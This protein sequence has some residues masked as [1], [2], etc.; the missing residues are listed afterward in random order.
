MSAVTGGWVNV[1]RGVRESF[2]GAWQ[3]HVSAD[4]PQTL[5]Q[6]SVI[7]ACVTG[8]AQDVSKLRIKLVENI[9]G[10]WEEVTEGKPWLPVLRKPNGYQTRIQFIRQWVVSLLL[11]GNT[12]VLKARD[13]RRIVT[14]FYVLNP[15]RV[16]PLVSDSGDV[17]YE[18]KADYLSGVEEI[19]TVPA[20]EIIHDRMTELWHPLVGVPPIYACAVSGTLGNKIQ[21]NSTSL[22]ANKG[23]PGGT[24]ST[25]KHIDQKVADEIAQAWDEN[26]GGDNA[27][28]IAV[29]GDG[30][31]FEAIE[32][33][34][35]NAQVAEQLKWT[36]EDCARAF[37]YPITKL[38]AMTGGAQ[39]RN[40]E[41][42]AMAYYEDCLQ[43]IIEN[44][45]LLLDEGLALPG[46]LGTEFDI[47]NLMRMDTGALYE[48]INKA[49]PWMKLDEQR[50]KANYAPLP[51]GGN[52]VYKQHQDY[53]IEALAKRDKADP[54]GTAAKT[55][56]PTPADPNAERDLEPIEL[57][58]L[59]QSKAR[60]IV[61]AA[62]R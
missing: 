51:I 53:S 49:S 52:T 45:E 22:F 3:R 32:M 55:T 40:V 28:R 10:I 42:D 27:G 12:Y 60:E 13:G 57:I 46:N 58:D 30:M 61:A 18:L 43:S 16:T 17:Y 11:A 39:Q 4:P 37:H 54:F 21:A 48:S 50:R 31:K 6:F 47:D 41:A 29:L 59:I 56:S 5:L 14:G 15:L 34:L 8:I 38:T 26:Y 24:L 35:Q 2:T 33:T 7:Y 36:V 1:F 25:E 19:V 62:M 44:I 20:S 9:D 23:M